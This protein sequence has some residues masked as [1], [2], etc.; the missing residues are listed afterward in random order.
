MAN[1]TSYDEKDAEWWK[2]AASRLALALAATLLFGGIVFAMKGSETR[3]LEAFKK[4]NDHLRTANNTIVQKFTEANN[5]LKECKAKNEELKE[6]LLKLRVE[7]A[8]L[9]AM[10]DE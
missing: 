6:A 7:N 8:D 9:K 2:K 4:S 10:V 1:K 3:A 5:E